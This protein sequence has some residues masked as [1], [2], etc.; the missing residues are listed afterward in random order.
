MSSKGTLFSGAAKMVNGCKLHQVSINLVH[1]SPPGTTAEVFMQQAFAAAQS[2]ESGYQSSKQARTDAVGTQASVREVVAEFC[3]GARDAHKPFLGR[4]W[5]PAWSA[6]GFKN[7]SLKLARSLPDQIEC[8]R[9]LK[10]YFMNHSPQEQPNAQLTATMAGTHLTT[11]NT[12]VKEVSKT[13]KEQRS[14]RQVRD[15][16]ETALL[17]LQRKLRSELDAALEPDDA[18]WLD[19]IDALPAD[20]QV[21]EAVEDF[22]AE[23]DG[24]G[25]L[26]LEWTPSVRAERYLIEA[27]QIGVDADFR[28]VL[29]VTD[30][31]ADL[32]GLVP[33]ARYR[34]RVVAAN[35]AGESAPSAVVEI[36]VPAES[37]AA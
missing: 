16:T 28:R 15:A 1:V 23:G 9:C 33:G 32:E 31:S 36:V 11:M 22:M 37:A 18:R 13:K 3:L 19:F 17:K 2:G 6:A 14:A 8:L 5:N 25:G 21:P 10:E 27:Q 7:N 20:T 26:G 34:L 12:A 29:T 4:S 30:P 35:R 24:P